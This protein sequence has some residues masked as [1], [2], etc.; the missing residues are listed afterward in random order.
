LRRS[1][2][3]E[4]VFHGFIPVAPVTTHSGPLQLYAWGVRRGALSPSVRPRPEW[5]GKSKVG[6]AGS[7]PERSDHPQLF[8][9]P[10]VDTRPLTTAAQLPV[11]EYEAGDLIVAIT[12]TWG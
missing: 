6:G 12:V 11:V 3:A 2:V 9:G 10:G 4:D 7:R 8:R 1:F 5:A